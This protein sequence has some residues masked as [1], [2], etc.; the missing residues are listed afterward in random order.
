[1]QR[2][3][4]GFVEHALAG[5]VET[6]QRRGGRMLRDA[7]GHVRLR[8]AGLIG[9]IVTVAAVANDVDD[10]IAAKG[11]TELQG[12]LRGADDFHRAIAIHM[13]DGR[14]D[15][16]RHVGAVV[17]RTG[18]LRHR[19][20]A[21]LVVHDEVDRAA[22]AVTGKLREIQHLR[23]ETLAGESG[24]TMDEHRDDLLAVLC[25]AQ[26]TLTGTC[27]AFYDRIDRF[28]V[29]RVRREHHADAVAAASLAHGFKAEVILHIAIAADHV[30]HVVLA[31]LVK[32]ILQRLAQEIRQHAEAATM[33]HAEHDFLAAVGWQAFEDR[34]QRHEQGLATFHGETLLPHETAMQEALEAFG[35]QQPAQRIHLLLCAGFW[36]FGDLDAIQQPGADF[37]IVDVP[38]LEAG[39]ATIDAAQLAEHRFELH[40]LTTTEHVRLHVFLEFLIR[41]AKARERERRDVRPLRAE[42][43]EMRGGVSES[44]EVMDRVRHAHA[45]AQRLFGERALGSFRGLRGQLGH[46]E[47]ET[48]K[49]RRPQR[50]DGGRVFFP[51]DV[52]RLKEVRVSAVGERGTHWGFYGGK[53]GGQSALKLGECN[54]RTAENIHNQPA[55]P[56]LCPRRA[57]TARRRPLAPAF[58]RGRRGPRPR[59]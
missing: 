4:T 43:I 30:G 32:E 39:F 47:L 1:M 31:E 9:L 34:L 50:L 16:L 5:E 21:D 3:G 53:G 58:C 41:E 13:E 49:E 27:H 12:E 8:E 33:G 17:G 52:F 55:E 18:V 57:L 59:R 35:L 56:R 51:V 2:R 6:E 42:R 40:R 20:E 7:A 22:G 26:R 45:E 15:H 29:A 54:Q 24:V 11:L 38:E 14:L 25:I 46:A 37:W 19:G 10:D 44:A 28:K 48:F 36:R 23:D